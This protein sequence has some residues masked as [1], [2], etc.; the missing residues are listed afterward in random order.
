MPNLTGGQLLKAMRDSSSTS[1]IPVI[2][3]TSNEDHAEEVRLM[4]AG[5]DDYIRK[6][7]DP[8]RFVARVRAAL[9]RVN[10]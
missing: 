3:L 8:N 2:V 4:D 5:A 1:G 6:P 10:L 9:R 7:I